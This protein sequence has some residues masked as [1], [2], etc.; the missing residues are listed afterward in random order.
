MSDKRIKVIEVATR[1]FS[2]KG[3]DNTSISAIGKEAGVSKALVFHHFQNKD[4]LLIEVFK[5]S[6]NV[7]SEYS[8]NNKTTSVDQLMELLNTFFDRLK[9]EKEYFQFSI[10][11]CIQQSTRDLLHDLIAERSAGI[12]KY[13]Q[14]LFDALGIENSLAKSYMLIA[15]LDGIAI[16]YIFAFTH[17]PFEEIRQEMIGKYQL[18]IQNT[19]TK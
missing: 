4:N 19:K 10:N 13:I 6:T 7:I 16:N 11:I 15:E 8:K 1:L 17:Y 14:Q 9:V 18:L 12:Q 3:F 2:E 5:Q